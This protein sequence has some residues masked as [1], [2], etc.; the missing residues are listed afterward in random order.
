MDKRFPDQSP[1]ARFSLSVLPSSHSEAVP[2]GK[3]NQM[4]LSS[5]E[6][7]KEHSLIIE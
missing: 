5:Q 7:L 4:Y 2:A 6:N 1:R 3:E